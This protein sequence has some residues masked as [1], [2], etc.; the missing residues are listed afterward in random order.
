MNKLTDLWVARLHNL[1]EKRCDT[2]FRLELVKVLAPTYKQK[3]PPTG[4]TSRPSTLQKVLHDK[5]TTS[6]E[7]GRPYSKCAV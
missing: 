2:K 5:M 1:Y 4:G 3:L 6:T 7:N